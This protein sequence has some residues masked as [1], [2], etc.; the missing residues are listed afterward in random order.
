[1]GPSG[2]G[3]T[4]TVKIIAGIAEVTS[5]ETRVLGEKMPRL[6]LMNNIGYM[7]QSDALYMML[8]AA[9]NLEFFA[10]LYGMEKRRY[11]KRILEVME[12]V[13]LAD[14]L[15]KPVGAYSGGMKRRLSLAMAI[16]HDPKVLILDEPTVGI[17]PLL[18]R[19]I[20]NE[21]SHMCERGVT[22][23]V[24]TH[25]MDEALKCHQLAMM[26]S[27]ALIAQGTPLELQ[28]SVSASSIEEAFI[29]YGGGKHED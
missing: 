20:W 26:R 19:D 12:L 1:L 16:L 8:S 4:T 14:D 17:D 15:D 21:L 3:K 18:R 23:L 27:G 28:E 7:A 2:C 24:T 5:G 25:V 13:N 9:D 11:K 22:I 10:A 29:R 6:S